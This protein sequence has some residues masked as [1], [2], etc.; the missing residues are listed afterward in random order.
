MHSLPIIDI[1]PLYGSDRYAMPLFA[2]PLEQ[3]LRIDISA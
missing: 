2:L 3:K 1:A